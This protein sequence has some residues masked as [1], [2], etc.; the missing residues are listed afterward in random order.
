MKLNNEYLIPF[1]GLKIGKHQFTFEITNE[2]FKFFDN[3]EFNDVKITL[4]IELDKKNTLM[5][6]DFKYN[7]H[8]N[9]PCDLT[10]EPFDLQIEGINKLFVKFGEEYNMDDED[11]MILPYSAHEIDISHY[12]YE[13]LCMSVPNKRVHPGVKDGSLKSEILDKLKELQPKKNTEKAETDPMWD[14]LKKLLTDK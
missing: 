7:G 11:L 6:L 1:T 14:N 13:I 3:E 9:V 4:D 12:I 10:I 5:E 8:V 2:F